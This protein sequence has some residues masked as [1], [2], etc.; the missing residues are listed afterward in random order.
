MSSRTAVQSALVERA[1]ALAPL[2]RAH[3]DESERSR[4]LATPVVDAFHEAG[5]FRMLQPMSVG[6]SGLNAIEAVPILE[7]IACADGSA[8]WN[9][10][11]GAGN[12]AFLA[13]LEDRGALESLVKPPRSLG[14]GSVNPTSLRLVSV[15]G[16][17]RVSG[18]LRFAS[19]VHQATWIVAGGLVLE[20]GK[21]RLASDG[22]PIIVGAF[23]PSSELHIQDTWRPTGMAGT[24]SHDALVDDVFVPTSFTFDFRAK[25]SRSFDALAELPTFSRLGATLAAVA[26][27]IARRACDELMALAQT[28]PAM[29]SITPL[30]ETARVQTEVARA[31]AQLD[32]GRAHLEH[33][34]GR[35]FARVEA[36]ETPA[37]SDLARLRLAYLSATEH[38]VDAVD[39]MHDCAG[40]SAVASGNAL[41]RCFR[42][43]HV[44]TQH[45]AISPAHY[46]RVGKALLGLD[47]GSGQ[48]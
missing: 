13:L 8:G 42:D 17:Y 36:G 4:R 14:A 25:G 38:A 31:M 16:G 45:L 32:A 7:E 24:G 3:A 11:I 40:M 21:P 46:E 41:D 29:M 22:L 12:S 47:I 5:L 43:I 20:D 28:K 23:F 39:R 18:T 9:L 19:G 35:I 37:M 30:R 44:L 27:G 1:R 10:A 33:V 34:A 48:L 6:G 26:L 15:P 2:I